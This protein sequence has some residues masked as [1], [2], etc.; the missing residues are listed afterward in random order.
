MTLDAVPDTVLGSREGGTGSRDPGG[1]PGRGGWGARGGLVNG[2]GIREREGEEVLEVVFEV[3]VLEGE[4]LETAEG[5]RDE[6]EE[7]EEE[8]AGSPWTI[9][10]PVSRS[11]SIV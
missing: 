6:E 2:L 9:G 11:T 7:E 10:S 3:E 1:G 8:G 4:D 5:I